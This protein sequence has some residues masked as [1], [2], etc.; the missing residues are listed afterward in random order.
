MFQV[1]RVIKCNQE[2]NSIKICLSFTEEKT[3][4]SKLTTLVSAMHFVQLVAAVL[5]R[6]SCPWNVVEAIVSK[7]V[8]VA[9]SVMS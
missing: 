5:T 4:L 1:K 7:T 9:Y 6:L 8:E 3:C 2:L